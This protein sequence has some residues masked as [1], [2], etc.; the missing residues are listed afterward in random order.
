MFHIITS[1]RYIIH[2]WMLL[3]FEYLTENGSL[4]I[5]S[6]SGLEFASRVG[7]GNTVFELVWL[8]WEVLFWF[9]VWFWSWGILWWWRSIWSWFVWWWRWVCSS[10][11]SKWPFWKSSDTFMFLVMFAIMMISSWECWYS[12]DESNNDKDLWEMNIYDFINKLSMWYQYIIEIHSW[13][14]F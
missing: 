5:L 14:K 10:F 13:W 12:T 4:V 2:R 8:W 6:F 3:C 1:D 7:I 9:A 11:N